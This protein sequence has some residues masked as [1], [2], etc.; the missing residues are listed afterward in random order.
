MDN[1]ISKFIM[2]KVKSFDVSDG[3]QDG[4]IRNA[5]DAKNLSIWLSQ[6]ESTGGLNRHEITYV[7]ET[8]ADYEAWA[9]NQAKKEEES[10]VTESAKKYVKQIKKMMLD[11][12]TIDTQSEALTLLQELSN[13]AKNWNNADLEYF[14]EELRKA[15]YGELVEQFENM[16]SLSQ[17]GSAPSEDVKP[18]E[19]LETPAPKELDPAPNP[20][21]KESEQA[22]NPAPKELDPTP[23]S[24]PKEPEQ[25]PK[26][27]PKEP[28][29]APNSASNELD[30]APKSAPR[31]PEQAP[32]P[33]PLTEEQ[34]NQAYES[35]KDVA[36]FLVGVTNDSEERQTEDIIINDVT[37]QNVMAFL[38]GYFDN[39]GLGDAF[40]EQF[41]SEMDFDRKQEMMKNVAAK[42]SEY[43]KAQ[44]KTDKTAFIDGIQQVEISGEIAKELDKIISEYLQL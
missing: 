6:Q 31:E 34:K 10:K 3:K 35:G 25:A 12:K 17:K 13:V 30:P 21:P 1:K 39:K 8:I 24:A 11:R 38:K 27:A 44:G 29:Q 26:S 42:L 22:P 37:P 18:Q 5:N 32:N 15:G 2:D 40:F 19:S 41:E 28:G 7:K 4:K 23:K 14:R 9:D 16:N 43:L 33:A 36:D 20:A